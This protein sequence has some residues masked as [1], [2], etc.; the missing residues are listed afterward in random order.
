MTGGAPDAG[1][2]GTIVV[3]I[4]GGVLGGWLFSLAGDE[5]IGDFGLRSMFVAFV[6]ACVLL[7]IV[8]LFTAAATATSRGTRERL[9]RAVLDVRGREP[10]V[11]LGAGAHFVARP[12][13]S[14]S[15]TTRWPWRSI[16]K[17]EPLERVGGEHEL[18]AVGVDARRC[19]RGW[20][21]RTS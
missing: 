10:E 19:P 4:I 17:I 9:P 2:L 5:G 18:A 3:G 6:G 1:C 7:L 12:S 16:R 13:P 8:G 15:N 14:S 20:R 21:G 11:G